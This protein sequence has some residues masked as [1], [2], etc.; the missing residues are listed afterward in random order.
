MGLVC[1]VD[2]TSFHVEGITAKSTLI[3]PENSPTPLTLLLK[4]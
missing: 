2:L 1:S 4:G 3:V